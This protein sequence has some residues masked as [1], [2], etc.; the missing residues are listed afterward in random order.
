MGDVFI[1]VYNVHVPLASEFGCPSSGVGC[2]VTLVFLPLLPLTVTSKWK[3]SRDRRTNMAKR[4]TCVIGNPRILQIRFVWSESGFSFGNSARK[5]SLD[6]R[7]APL[8]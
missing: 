4:R 1:L 8:S 2:D 3:E 7:G 6:R 5:S